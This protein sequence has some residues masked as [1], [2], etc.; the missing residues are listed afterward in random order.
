L[1]AFTDSRISLWFL[2]RR[3]HVLHRSELISIVS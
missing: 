3:Q 1:K 2:F